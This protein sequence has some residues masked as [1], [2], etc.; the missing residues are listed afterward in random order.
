M[1]ASPRGGSHHHHYSPLRLQQHQ[2]QQQQLGG[3]GG[4]LSIPLLRLLRYAAAALG[5][6]ALGYRHGA[7]QTPTVP[8]STALPGACVW[9]GVGT[10]DWDGGNET[11]ESR[12][13][14]R[15]WPPAAPSLKAIGPPVRPYSPPPPPP[16]PDGVGGGGGGSGGNLRS[17]SPP[18]APPAAA[19]GSRARVSKLKQGEREQRGWSGRV[20]AIKPVPANHD[21]DDRGRFIEKQVCVWC[22][23]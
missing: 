7:S 13:I 5:V 20:A 17:A 11:M 1:A 19:S 10:Y 23:R 18:V 4:L 12:E 22:V 2:H 3:R 15:H 8:A 21:E 9:G 14:P 16:T 6:Y